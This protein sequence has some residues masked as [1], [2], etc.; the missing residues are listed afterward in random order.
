MP[1]PTPHATAFEQA[2]AL[3]PSDLRTLITAA[4]W[5]PSMSTADVIERAEAEGVLTSWRGGL[6]GL[7][8]EIDAYRTQAINR[9]WNWRLCDAYGREEYERQMAREID[10]THEITMG[11]MTLAESYRDSPPPFSRPSD[12]KPE[13]YPI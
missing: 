9:G 7:L 10:R 13:D 11:R 1:N 3:T 6:P 8:A 12:P 4:E 5:R 2:G